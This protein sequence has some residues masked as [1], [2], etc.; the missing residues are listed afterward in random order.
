LQPILFFY[1]PQLLELAMK[2][3]TDKTSTTQSKAVANKVS[4][5]KDN[6]GADVQFDDKRQQAGKIAQLQAMANGGGGRTVQRLE[7]EDEVKQPKLKTVQRAPEEDEVK[8]PKLKTV[9]R[10]PEEDEV[11][12]PKLKTVQ[13]APE[14]DEVKQPKLETVQRA[15]EEDEVK[16]PK[17]KT[18]QRA[19]EEDEVKQ[20]K[21]KTVQR[22]PEEDE[23]KQPKLKTVQR[24]PEEDEVK[25][26]K[27]KTVQRAPEEDEVKQPKL[28]TVQRAPEEDEVKQ[29]KLKTVQRAVNEKGIQNKNATVQKKADK[30]TNNTGLPDNLKT[31][32][33]NL[34]GFSLDDVKVHYNSPEPAQLK[35]HAFAQGTDIHMAPGQEKHL[36]HEAWHVV[37]QKQGRVKP[38]MQMKGKVNVNDDAGLEKEADVMGAKAMN[39]GASPSNLHVK[40][41][42][43]NSIHKLKS[44]SELV[45]CE[46]Q[47]DSNGTIQLERNE[48]QVS[49]AKYI[50]LNNNVTGMCTILGKQYTKSAAGELLAVIGEIGLKVAALAFLPGVVDAGM[51][52][53]EGAEGALEMVG[54]SSGIQVAKLAGE[55]GREAVE[56]ANNVNVEPTA[57]VSDDAVKE[58]SLTESTT[59]YVKDKFNKTNTVKRAKQANNAIPVPGLIKTLATG[60]GG[61]AG[62]IEDVLEPA[63]SG[64]KATRKVATGLAAKAGSSKAQKQR[65]KEVDEEKGDLLRWLVEGHGLDSIKDFGK[66]YET[67]AG[68]KASVD[69]ENRFSVNKKFVENVKKLEALAKK[70]LEKKKK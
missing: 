61:L 54:K 3:Q 69:G 5:P 60:F 6:G 55:A 18:V 70:K 64:A 20:P 13:R 22:A 39:V 45:Q 41:T 11:K 34:S 17:L 16:Q 2:E 42:P 32:M 27:L 1:S 7:E 24:A 40:R 35:A 43:S 51:A 68:K 52:A 23:V 49:L 29:P 33:E 38:T 26:P 57:E 62:A 65:D 37:Q 4:A 10:A 28:K 58:K 21:L 47:N 53:I 48:Q 19:P 25:Q 12:Q 9:Q 50:K 63:K 15:P 59:D 56:D 31:G 14:E 67:A 8:Q 46:S 30:P 44:S 36:P 66:K